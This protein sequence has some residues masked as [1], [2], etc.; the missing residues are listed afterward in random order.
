MI[1]LI[2]TDM[3]KGSASTCLPTNISPDKPEA[4]SDFMEKACGNVLDDQ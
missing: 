4:L 1:N 3:K 2:R